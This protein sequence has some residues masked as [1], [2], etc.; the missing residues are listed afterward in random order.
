LDFYDLICIEGKINHFKYND[1]GV[2]VFNFN[3]VIEEVKNIKIEPNL[4][5]LNLLNNKF[6]Q[7]HTFFEYLALETAKL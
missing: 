2:L 1:H 7:I 5:F 3:N 6:K 4:G